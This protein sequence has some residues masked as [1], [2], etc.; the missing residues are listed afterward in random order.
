[1]LLLWKLAASC[2]PG[3]TSS[4]KSSVCPRVFLVYLPCRDWLLLPRIISRMNGWQNE[5]I[6]LVLFIFCYSLFA[7]N[8]F[9]PFSFHCLNLQYTALG[10]WNHNGINISQRGFCIFITTDVS[11]SFW[12]EDKTL[13]CRLTKVKR[14]AVSWSKLL[15]FLFY[16]CFN[17]RH[18]RDWRI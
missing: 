13:K 12:K 11:F 9:L 7:T 5:W 1:M 3:V 2:V 16:T 8:F 18:W 14:A 17:M 4:W 15:Y 10:G 6:H